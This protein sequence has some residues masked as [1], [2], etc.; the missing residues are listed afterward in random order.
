MLPTA[1]P[2]QPPA[3]TSYV[4]SPVIRNLDKYAQKISN[5]IIENYSDICKHFNLE[6][7]LIIACYAADRGLLFSLFCG[8]VCVCV[9]V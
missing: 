2:L 5:V 9:C 1:A 4:A 8:C 7:S 3:H 6:I